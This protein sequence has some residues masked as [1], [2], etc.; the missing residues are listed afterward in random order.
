MAEQHRAPLRRVGFV[1]FRAARPDAGQPTPAEAL[2]RHLADDG[3]EV[4]GVV[5]IRQGRASR[6][7]DQVSAPLRWRR[8]ADVVVVD[9]FSGRS[10]VSAEA[11]AT[12]ARMVGLP[13]VLVLHG[14]NLPAF[15][16]GHRRRFEHLLASA[17][18]VVAPSG[19][20][21]ELS[22]R[23]GREATVIP[24]TVEL[25]AA[26]WRDRAPLRPQ[27]LWLRSFA[28]IYNP[29]LAVEVVA[30]LVADHPEVQLTM[31][32]AD[33]G[34]RVA[35]EARAHALGVAD[36]I[37]FPGFLDAAARDRALDRCDVLLNT[38][39]VDNMP[40]SLLEAMA[41]GLVVVTTDAG[42]IPAMVTDGVDA[43]VRPRGDA[44]ALAAAVHDV[45]VDPALA[46]R[47]AAGG[48]RRVEGLSWHEVGPAWHAVLAAAIADDRGARSVPT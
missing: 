11:A 40:V 4:V 28:P 9:V 46:R 24:N 47:L 23:H 39:D 14:G 8:R 15:A 6:L 45:L 16:E 22:M 33:K 26:T 38:N 20:L 7:L 32:G 12:A 18:A 1:G 17:A 19:F 29:T 25:A 2:A 36:R 10:F 13:V 42:G 37:S 34:E 30:A 41:C 21:A 3:V 35:T 44:G 43:A 31:A 27:L 48:R 5:S